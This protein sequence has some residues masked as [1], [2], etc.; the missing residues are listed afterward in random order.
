MLEICPTIAE[1]KVKVEV[2]PLGIGGKADPARLVFNCPAGPALNATI[3]DLGN[4]FRMIVN[5]VEAVLPEQDLP[6]LPVARVLWKVKPDLATGAAA[7]I[8]AGGAHHTGYSQN[9]TA[10]Y[11]EDFAEM[12]GIEFVIID[13]DTKLRT[14]KNELRYNEVAF[15]G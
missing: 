11:L 6:K 14:F 8:L 9:L 3:V 5:E 4:R 12:A 2:H 7:W 13:A 15:R 1:G 10:E